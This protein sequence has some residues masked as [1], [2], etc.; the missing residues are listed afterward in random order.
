MDDPT[1]WDQFAA[2]YAAV[3]RESRL[4]LAHDVIGTLNQWQPL[5]NWTAL[6]LAAGSGRYTKALASQCQ[7][8]I[9]LDWSHNM[10]EETHKSLY[11]TQTN[12]QLRQADWRKL[13]PN[14]L[15]DLVFVSQLPTLQAQQL[16]QLTQ[17]AG[18]MVCL[19]NQTRQETDLT[20]RIA[21]LLNT[22]VQVPLQADPNRS[23]SFQTWLKQEHI[24]YYYRR[25][26]Y[27]LTNQIS[28]N[29]LLPDLARPVRLSEAQDAAASLTGNAD[30]NQL[31]NATTTYAFDVIAWQVDDTL[32]QQL[33]K[34]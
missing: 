1:S 21:A 2:T 12:V 33:A 23:A 15:A 6:D 20:Q 24:P 31:L 14:T 22:T 16:A 30:P 11:A 19:N 25:L 10:L 29:E 3:Q 7:H 18:K 13:P 32:R 8:V 9:A 5:A 4:P 34:K 28:I 17:L 27:S 26:T